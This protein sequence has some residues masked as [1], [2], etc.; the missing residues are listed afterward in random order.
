MKTTKEFWTCDRGIDIL[1]EGNFLPYAYP[2][3]E[4]EHC[5]KHKIT[6]TFDLPE[7]KIEIT[8]SEFSEIFMN[9]FGTNSSLDF[10]NLKEKLFDKGE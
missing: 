5:H 2:V 1:K 6:V 10:L 3:R 7:K 8:E 4:K 9:T